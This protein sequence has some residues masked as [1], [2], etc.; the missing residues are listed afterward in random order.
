VFANLNFI[1]KLILKPAPYLSLCTPS[2]IIQFQIWNIYI[3]R[4]KFKRAQIFKVRIIKRFR[5]TKASV[6]TIIAKLQLDILR[7]VITFISR[8]RHDYR[9]HYIFYIVDSHSHLI[10]FCY[11]ELAMTG[12]FRDVSVFNYVLCTMLSYYNLNFWLELWLLDACLFVT[13]HQRICRSYDDIFK[14]ITRIYFSK[15]NYCSA[16]L[17][18][19]I[20]DWSTK[21]TFLEPI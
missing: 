20:V 15:R 12:F 13:W 6:C 2:H 11:F 3:H 10:W 9:L 4:N 21:S 7:R 14:E 16:S 8:W 18:D 1:F 19:N 17:V 5:D